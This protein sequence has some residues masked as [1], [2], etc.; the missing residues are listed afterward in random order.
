MVRDD[1]HKLKAG[2]HMVVGTPGRVYDMIEKKALL[3]DKMKLFILDEADEMLSRG[4]K[5]QIQDGSSH[6]DVILAI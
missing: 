2:V 4:F 3:T 5:G 6:P 1:V